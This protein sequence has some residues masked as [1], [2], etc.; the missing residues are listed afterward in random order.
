MFFLLIPLITLDALMGS[1]RQRLEAIVQVYKVALFTIH[2]RF[3]Q[4][5]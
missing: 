1:Q 2:Y 3:L 5:L 4:Q